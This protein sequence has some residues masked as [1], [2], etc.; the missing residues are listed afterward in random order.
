M[1]SAI[2]KKR[3]DLYNL[4]TVSVVWAVYQKPPVQTAKRTANQTVRAFLHYHCDFFLHTAHFNPVVV[5]G[6][7]YK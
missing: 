2:Y 6:S 7:P 5:I 3:W 1:Q 4:Q